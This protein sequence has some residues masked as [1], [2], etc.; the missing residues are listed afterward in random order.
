M[1]PPNPARIALSG[2]FTIFT[3]L[4]VRNQLMAA[5]ADADNVEVDLSQISEIDS[6]GIQLMMAASK[7]AEA[8]QKALRFVDHSPAVTDALKLLEL[9]QFLDTG[10]PAALP[11]A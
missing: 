7:E 9:A 6:A 8:T 3:A 4:P 11:Q 2:E 10:A 5:L 1:P